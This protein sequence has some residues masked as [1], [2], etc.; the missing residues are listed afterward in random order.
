MTILNSQLLIG[1]ILA[2]LI[3]FSS[4]KIGFLSKSG[5]M[6]ACLLGTIVFGLGGFAWAVVLMGFF[7]SSSALSKLFKRRKTSLEEK[8]SKGSKRDAWQVWANGGVA[9]IFVILHAIF[10]DNSWPWLAFCGT[11]AAVNADTWATELGVLSKKNPINLVTGQSLDAGASGGVTLL[12]T[13]SAFLASLFIAILAILFWPAFLQKP[14]GT[15]TWILV[16]GI[17]AA[18]VFGSL[19]DSFLGATVQAI[20][21]CPGCAK[22]TEKHPLHTCGRTTEIVRGWKWFTN[23]VVNTFCAFMG[24]F[25]MILSTMLK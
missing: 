23:D 11:M 1:F 25:V 5:A 3:A 9:G 18:G 22:E 14:T 12:G 6:A 8:F 21:F 24:G 2:V 4:F 7:I 10:P 20:Y 19:V 17:T 16:T 15:E 13:F